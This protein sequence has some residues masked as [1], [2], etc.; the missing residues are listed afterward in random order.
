MRYTDVR[1]ESD[2]YRRS[3]ARRLNRVQDVGAIGEAEHW[4][5][6]DGRVELQRR[7]YGGIGRPVAPAVFLGDYG[8]DAEGCGSAGEPGR[9]SRRSDRARR[10][11]GFQTVAPERRL[12][13]D[14]DKQAV[15]SRDQRHGGAP[16]VPS[17]NSVT[18]A[19]PGRYPFVVST[20]IIGTSSRSGSN[21]SYRA[22]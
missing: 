14:D 2:E 21:A 3:P 8:G 19:R 11:L 6:E 15:V 9:S 7:D 4:L 1:L 5:G 13:V 20:S 16:D 10:V 12:Q 18:A 17:A 22:A